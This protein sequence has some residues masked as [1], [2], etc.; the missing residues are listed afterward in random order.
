MIA[1]F[2]VLNGKF[3]FVGD[4]TVI[5]HFSE[6]LVDMI[7]ERRGRTVLVA[8]TLEGD[9][10]MK[11]AGCFPS[12]TIA[13][14]YQEGKS[15]EYHNAHCVSVSINKA[16]EQSCRDALTHDSSGDQRPLAA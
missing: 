6:A 12:P 16:M 14:E 9:G 1:G 4:R 3:V 15:H 13:P 11:M 5:S 2:G 10:F 8:R 7:A